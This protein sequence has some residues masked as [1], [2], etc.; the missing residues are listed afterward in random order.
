MSSQIEEIDAMGTGYKPM[1][2][3]FHWV[4]IL[5]L[6]MLVYPTVTKAKYIKSHNPTQ[7]KTI[8]LDPG[9]GGHDRPR[10]P[11]SPLPGKMSPSY[12]V[13]PILPPIEIPVS[14]WTAVAWQINDKQHK[15][16]ILRILYSF[17][18]IPVVDWLLAQDSQYQALSAGYSRVGAANSAPRGTSS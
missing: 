18:L 2:F 13:I 12:L 7:K 9:H 6:V 4:V 14:P 3:R 15:K 1:L 11:T 17:A 10:E 16:I 5:Y 8:V